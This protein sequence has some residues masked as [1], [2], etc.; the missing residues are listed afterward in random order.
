[1]VISKKKATRVKTMTPLAATLKTA[2][3][4]MPKTTLITPK[5]MAKITVFRKLL[6][7]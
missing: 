4:K 2:E 3:A 5:R 7:N 6:P 1:M